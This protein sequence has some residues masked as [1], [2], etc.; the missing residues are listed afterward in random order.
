MTLIPV[1]TKDL[2]EVNHIPG[3]ARLPITLLNAPGID[4]S[5]SECRRDEAGR[6]GRSKNA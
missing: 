4:P 1:K 6:V 2:I 3:S 5:A